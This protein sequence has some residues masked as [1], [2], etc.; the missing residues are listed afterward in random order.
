VETLR[1]VWVQQFVVRADQA[2]KLA[3][4]TAEELPASTELIRSPYDVEARYAKKRQTEWT[5]YKV[6]LTPDLRRRVPVPDHQRRDDPCDHHG[7]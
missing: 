1:Q 2:G 7:L 5:G 4:R 6:H 3:W